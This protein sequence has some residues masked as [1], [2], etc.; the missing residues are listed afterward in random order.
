MSLVRLS[1]DGGP[2]RWEWVRS[3]AMA[4]TPDAHDYQQKYRTVDVF[5]LCGD[6][7][8]NASSLSNPTKSLLTI[9]PINPRLIA[10]P[11]GFWAAGLAAATITAATRSFSKGRKVAAKAFR[12]ES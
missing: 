3:N 11:S 2:L 5:D 9:R 4:Q 6:V 1:A 8:V 10:N 12:I 7:S